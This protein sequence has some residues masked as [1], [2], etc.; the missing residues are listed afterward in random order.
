M[1]VYC[2]RC[3]EESGRQTPMELQEKS[4]SLLGDLRKYY[5]CPR[6]GAKIYIEAS[7]EEDQEVEEFYVIVS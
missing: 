3:E 4:D 2:A 1:K 5:R 7:D 6:C